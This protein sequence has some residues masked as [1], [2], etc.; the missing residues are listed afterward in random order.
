MSKVILNPKEG[1]NRNYNINNQI[2]GNSNGITNS[3]RESN[4]RKELEILEEI[5]EDYDVEMDIGLE[6]SNL[7]K[8][9]EPKTSKINL[10]LPHRYQAK[11]I[12]SPIMEHPDERTGIYS[13]SPDPPALSRYDKGWKGEMVHSMLDIISSVKFDQ[14][15]ETTDA[16]VSNKQFYNEG[17][18]SSNGSGNSIVGRG[19]FI[20][21]IQEEIIKSKKNKLN[22]SPIEDY[23]KL[24]GLNKLSLV[25]PVCVKK[26]TEEKNISN[27][28]KKQRKKMRKQIKGK[29]NRKSVGH[30]RPATNYSNEYLNNELVD[31]EEELNNNSNN[32]NSNKNNY[33]DNNLNA[34]QQ[35]QEMIIS[36]RPIKKDIDM[37]FIDIKQPKVEIEIKNNIEPKQTSTQKERRRQRKQRQRRRQVHHDRDI[38]WRFQNKGEFLTV[39]DR[40]MKQMFSWSRYEKMK[41]EWKKQ[42]VI[43]VERRFPKAEFP[44]INF[45]KGINGKDIKNKLDLLTEYFKAR[46]ICDLAG[47]K[48]QKMAKDQATIKMK[49][50]VLGDAI[51]LIVHKI[52]ENNVEGDGTFL[53]VQDI[54]DSE[55]MSDKD[56]TNNDRIGDTGT[57]RNNDNNNGD[58]VAAVVGVSL[59]SKLELLRLGNAWLKEDLKVASINL[60]HSKKSFD[61]HYSLYKSALKTCQEQFHC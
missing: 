18:G 25:S 44:R 13:I 33:N 57:S 26:T 16:T 22:E 19:D 59:H 35:Q 5:P 43:D 24:S 31:R 56:N 10:V 14:D 45:E 41:R 9:M 7:N 32:S 23:T 21:N 54:I 1:E 40:L 42:V 47:R 61:K 6:P 20:N 53:S 46:D 36:S 4:K 39:F 49:L 11:N 2:W 15:A 60:L 3:E 55:Y 50:D 17:S 51:V 34:S 30:I 37:V 58:K 48:V 28:V 52:N 8:M 12:L 29:K 38:I 27:K